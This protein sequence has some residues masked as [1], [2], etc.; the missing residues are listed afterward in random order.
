AKANRV[1]KRAAL[2]SHR[3]YFMCLPGGS[4]ILRGA[5][6]WAGWIEKIEAKMAKPQMGKALQAID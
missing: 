5:V 1:K 4:A 3:R 2:S 6:R